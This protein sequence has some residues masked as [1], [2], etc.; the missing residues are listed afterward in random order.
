[1]SGSLAF[2]SVLLVVHAC[3]DSFVLKDAHFEF[4][5]GESTIRVYIC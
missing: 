3:R 1:M 4:L 5:A 2:L